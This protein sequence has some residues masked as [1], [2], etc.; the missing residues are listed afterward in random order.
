MS[1]RRE[2]PYVDH[3]INSWRVIQLFLIHRWDKLNNFLKVK[4]NTLRTKKLWVIAYVTFQA[5]ISFLRHTVIKRS[6]DFPMSSP[7]ASL[8]A[9]RALTQDFIEIYV[10]P[11]TS[12]LIATR[13]SHVL[14]GTFVITVPYALSTK[15]WCFSEQ[16]DTLPKI[17][18]GQ[19]T[20]PRADPD[21]SGQMDSKCKSTYPW[22]WHSHVQ[23][24]G[25]LLDNPHK[26][27]FLFPNCFISLM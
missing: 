27:T 21:I 20:L 4:G 8:W 7:T 10:L 12:M 14:V 5:T 17:W 13:H 18:L 15:P 25:T 19:E 26:P 3:Y 11:C 1:G 6:S 24:S 9:V 2:M 22:G 16:K 23:F